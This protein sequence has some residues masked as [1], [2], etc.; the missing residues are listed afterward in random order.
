MDGFR[1]TL[2]LVGVINY[3]FDFPSE[4]KLTTTKLNRAIGGSD[5]RYIHFPAVTNEWGTYRNHYT[6]KMLP[7]GTVNPGAKYNAIL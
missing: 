7:D 5:L 4:K 6:P 1:T 2:W 3:E